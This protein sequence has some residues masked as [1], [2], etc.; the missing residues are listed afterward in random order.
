MTGLVAPLPVLKF[1]DNNGNPLAFGL[2][3]TFQ[4]GT[5]TPTQTYTDAT[6]GTPN[7][8]PAT[9]NFRGEMTMW[10][11]A[12]TAIKINVTDANGSQLPGWPQDNI[13][14]IQYI[15]TRANI[16][17]LLYPVVAG[18]VSVTDTSYPVGNPRRYGAVGDGVTDDTTALQNCVTSNPGKSVTFNQGDTYAVQQVIFTKGGPSEYN[19][20]GCTLRGVSSYAGQAVTFTAG[21]AANATSG[22]LNA[23]WTRMTG[24]YAMTF[25]T[26]E[27]HSVLLTNGG[28][29]ASWQAGLANAAT[30]SAN[31]TALAAALI[32]QF[33]ATSV[34]DLRVDC[35]NALLNPNFNYACAVQWYNNTA[36]SQFNAIY[37]FQILWSK[38]G[39]VFGELPGGLP[40]G[41]I[42]SEDAIYGF[43]SFGVE[44][45]FYGNASG[46]FLHFSEPIFY[47]GHENWTQTPNYVTGRALENPSGAI[48]CQGGEIESAASA[49]GF[50]ADL[51]GATLVGMNIE[52]APPLHI[53]G[54]GVQIIGGEIFNTQ[55]TTSS[56]TALAGITGKLELND[57]NIL[58]NAGVGAFSGSVMCDATAANAL[59]QVNLNG[60]IVSEWRWSLAGNNIRLVNGGVPNYR[61]VR[62]N[63]TAADGNWYTINTGPTE[64]MLPPLQL[65]NLGYTLTGWIFNL[66][67]GGGSSLTNTTSAG[68]PG[69][70]ASQL[71]L[72]ATGTAQAVTGDPTSLATIKAT[73]QRVQPGELY[74]PSC[75]IK[76][77]TGGTGA[78]LVANFY[79]LAGALLGTVAVADISGIGTNVWTYVEGPL[80]P[81]ALSAYM[82]VG[83]QGNVA[84]VLLTD[85]RVRRA[86]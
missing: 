4:A 6:L 34:Y 80:I 44:N 19:F 60:C 61:N 53:I 45:P 23:V 43:R 74:W 73:M 28:I 54:D 70:L 2:V 50:A 55:S 41:G 59:F 64:S 18:E 71:T 7:A 25:S 40:G 14:D 8:N 20:N 84:T 46:G 51:A 12:N 79:N 32:I 47:S 22:N 49:A 68:P 86:N 85:L 17:A 75:W 56:F 48:F 63:I 66:I 65:D 26:G 69:Y 13:Q 29:A 11:A 30:A 62:M 27:V 83:V 38:R 36:G 16:G 10:L 9:L 35:F 82:A 76:M 15:L 77:N 52:I 78:S 72:V 37:G 42:Q 33:Q 5:S 67:G 81:P 58:R 3:S 39:L 24:Y 21:L 57:V 1:F 31:V